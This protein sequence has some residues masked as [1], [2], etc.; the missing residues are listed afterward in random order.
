MGGIE[1]LALRGDVEEGLVGWSV[2]RWLVQRDFILSTGIGSSLSSTLSAITHV[3]SC[4]ESEM[5]VVLHT[6]GR[7]T[8]LN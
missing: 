6:S 5:A 3:K 1:Q 2:A 4:L 8:D 7:E